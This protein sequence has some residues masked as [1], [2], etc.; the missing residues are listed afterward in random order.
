MTKR[1][2]FGRRSAG[3][4]HKK[5]RAD[6]TGDDWRADKFGDWVYENE[7]FDAY[8]KAQNIM[9]DSDWPAF[10][11]AL[12]T[13]LPTTFRINSSCPFAERFV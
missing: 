10:K 4:G 6:E 7:N 2:R 9:S 3:R 5:P 1:S 13:P 12:A 8:Y 11:K